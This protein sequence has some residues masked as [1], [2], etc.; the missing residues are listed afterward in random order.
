M[1]KLDQKHVSALQDELTC[2]W[3][4]L[5]T[6]EN[7]NDAYQLFHSKL[8][9]TIN[10]YTEEKTVKISYKKI[11]REPWLTKGIIKSN[12]KQTKLY[13]EWLINKNAINYDR[14]KHYRDAL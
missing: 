3:Q 6:T 13:K 5:E 4:I 10:K 2:D 8:E 1:K 7:A 14:Y 11:I 9:S 12:R